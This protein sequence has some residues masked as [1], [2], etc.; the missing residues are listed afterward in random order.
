MSLVLIVENSSRDFALMDA[1]DFLS[2]ERPVL[3]GAMGAVA[4]HDL[5]VAVS[6]AGGL[7]TL[8]YLPA[9]AFAREMQRIDAS[10]SGKPFAANLLLPIID[11]RHVEACLASSVPIV[12][13]FYGFDQDIVDAL[14]SAGKIVLFQVGS[15]GEAQ[16]VTERGADGVIVQ[17]HEA[18]GHIRG[19]MRL[20]DLLPQV[21][22]AIPDKL[23]CAAGGIHDRETANRARSLGAHAVASGTRFL[24]S[25]EAAAHP[26]YKQR[27]LDANET[28]ATNLF[29][30]GWRD[31]HRVI[32][33]SA[34]DK[35]CAPNGREPRW[36]FFIHVATRLAAKV[37]GPNAADAMVARQSLKLPFYTPSSLTPEMDEEMLEVVALY[38]GECIEH[39][40]ALQTAAATV[41]ELA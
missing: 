22:D 9:E 15:V 24:A 41:D 30:V 38:A 11:K 27:L 1:C 5:V 25:P 33:N 19:T 36:L 10:L 21:C 4:R 39:I 3:Q 28:I 37:P 35:W 2:L 8:S 31:P 14:K 20:S 29:G 6:E 18:G 17:G 7:G 34:T 16:K 13:L 23:V 40:S 32:R 26:A 12:T